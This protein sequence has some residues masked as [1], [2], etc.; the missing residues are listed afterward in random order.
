MTTAPVGTTSATS[1]AVHGS[2]GN[3]D[4]GNGTTNGAG[5][6]SGAATTSGAGTTSAVPGESKNLH[7]FLIL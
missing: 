2:G 4:T 6:T 5:T 1:L 3:S 7:P